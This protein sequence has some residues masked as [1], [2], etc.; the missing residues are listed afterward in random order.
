MGWGNEGNC[1]QAF[2][3]A[4]SLLNE[5][6]RDKVTN[7]LAK[8]VPHFENFHEAIVKKIR[9]HRGNHWAEGPLP[10]D[11][12]NLALCMDGTRL[13]V[14]EP[15]DEYVEMSVYSGYTGTHCLGYL[16]LMAPDGM[17]VFL[18]GPFAG[19]F[20]DLD[21]VRLS[22]VNNALYEAQIGRNNQYW[23]YGDRIF[24]DD[25]YI[26]AA[27]RGNNI[28]FQMQQE[29]IPLK[30]IRSQCAELPFG[31][32]ANL[33]RFIEW[34]PAQQLLSCPVAKHYQN[35]VHLTNCHTILYGSLTGSYFDIF[36]HIRTLRELHQ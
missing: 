15:V 20:T 1:C 5:L 32:I 13:N 34:K 11:A 28:P 26:R 25:T 2:L 10:P 8:A 9:N 4:A 31:K 19:H 35:I 36:P 18:A 29:G 6:V 21:F 23:A 16:S 7:N 17:I 33:W 3:K 30:S 14:G 24:I 12:T 22:G 27:P